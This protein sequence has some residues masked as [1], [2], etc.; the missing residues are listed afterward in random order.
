[1]PTKLRSYAA[2]MAMILPFH[3]AFYQNENTFPITLVDMVKLG[4]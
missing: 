1:M 2:K 3:I 4:S